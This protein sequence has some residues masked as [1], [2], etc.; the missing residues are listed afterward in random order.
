VNNSIESEILQIYS[1]LLKIY[2][3]ATLLQSYQSVQ[4]RLLT[5]YQHIHVDLHAFG[6][7]IHSNKV[8]DGKHLKAMIW[9]TKQK[10]RHDIFYTLTKKNNSNVCTEEQHP[11][12]KLTHTYTHCLLSHTLYIYRLLVGYGNICTSS[13][14]E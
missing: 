7:N 12:I 4:L 9:F 8:N 1:R 6:Q 14:A 10:M 3:I 5:A 13:G 2:N 11:M